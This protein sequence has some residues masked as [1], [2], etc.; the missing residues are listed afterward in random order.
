VEL[1]R[2]LKREFRD[3]LDL[4][5]QEIQMPY[6]STIEEITREDIAVKLLKKGTIPLEEIADITGLSIEQIKEL[7]SEQN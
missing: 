6:I 3:E 2:G 1:P 4:Y 5:Q 7:Q